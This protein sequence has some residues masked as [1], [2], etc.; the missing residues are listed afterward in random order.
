MCARRYACVCIQVCTYKY[1]CVCDVCVCMSVYKHRK[2]QDPLASVC[3]SRHMVSTNLFLSNFFSLCLVL[4]LWHLIND[5]LVLRV[6]VEYLDL[7]CGGDN[8]GQS[9]FI[10]SPC[11]DKYVFPVHMEKAKTRFTIVVPW[12]NL[13]DIKLS[14]FPTGQSQHLNFPW[15]NEIILISRLRFMENGSVSPLVLHSCCTIKSQEPGAVSRT[16]FLLEKLRETVQEAEAPKR[17]SRH[18]DLGLLESSSCVVRQLEVDSS[19]GS[20]YHFWLR[21]LESCCLRFY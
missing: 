10:D 7:L 12:N 11:R 15:P 4:S 20:S 14:F 17:L 6:A 19:F 8:C 9:L 16:L 3:W 5:D 21:C 18:V 1:A 2:G 13:E